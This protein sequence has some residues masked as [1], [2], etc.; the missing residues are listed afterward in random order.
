MDKR[1]IGILLILIA[2]LSCMYV[3]VDNSN[4]VGNAITV[5]KD[6]S[7]VV[8]PGLRINGDTSTDVTLLNKDTNESIYIRCIEGNPVKEFAKEIKSFENKNNVEMN[9]R[10][11]S[12]AEI[13]DFENIDTGQ[14][15]TFVL[16]E[17]ANH[18]FIMKMDNYNSK[19]K[20]DKEM[21]F[22]IDNLKPDYK[23]NKG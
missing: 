10:S 2:G 22:V 15:T 12:T 23:Q 20:Q 5:I 14:N 6:V 18:P 1:W 21:M 11:N 9:N 13:I 8:P 4:S 3:I 19:E 17:K 7:I 16:F